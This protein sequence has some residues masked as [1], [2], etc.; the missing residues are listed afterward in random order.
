[1]AL[2][3]GGAILK[4]NGLGSA[5]PVGHADGVEKRVQLE[6]DCFEAERDFHAFSGSPGD[7]AGLS[8]FRD[9]KPFLKPGP[10]IGEMGLYRRTRAIASMGDSF[11]HHTCLLCRGSRAECE[12]SYGSFCP[13]RIIF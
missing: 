5:E 2:A 1:M 13:S 9:P 12:Q 4:K 3:G 11:R 10:H 8:R 7:R 6:N